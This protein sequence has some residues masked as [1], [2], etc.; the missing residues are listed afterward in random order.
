[1][2]TTLVC[3]SVNACFQKFNQQLQR[4][5]FFPD[6]P[7]G[8]S[9]G[10][11]PPLASLLPQIKHIALAMMPKEGAVTQSAKEFASGPGIESFCLSISESSLFG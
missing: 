11:A 8:L 9:E 7:M 2:F 1:M 5:V 10:R 6:N 3:T 4:Q